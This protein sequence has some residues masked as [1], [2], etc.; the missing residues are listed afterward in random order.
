MESSSGCDSDDLLFASCCFCAARFCAALTV[1]W[2][3]RRARPA[4]R[5]KNVESG[6]GIFE[7]FAIGRASI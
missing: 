6:R 5:K 3:M 4:E 7:R 1:L 2:A